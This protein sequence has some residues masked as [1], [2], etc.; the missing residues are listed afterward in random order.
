[1]HMAF[2]FSRNIYHILFFFPLRTLAVSCNNSKLFQHMAR[3]LELI[4]SFYF[5][6]SELIHTLHA[7]VNANGGF[8]GKLR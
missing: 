3:L 2:L 8:S 1:M 6:T 5:F 4:F 7:L